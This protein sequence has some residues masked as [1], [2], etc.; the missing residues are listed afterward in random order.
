MR[1]KRFYALFVTR[2]REFFR[3]RAALYWNFMF[4][5]IIILGF[6]LIFQRDPGTNYKFGVIPPEAGMQKFPGEEYPLEKTG[7]DHPAFH[8]RYREKIL[9]AL[10]EDVRKIESV[11]FLFF[12]NRQEGFQ[13]LINHRVDMLLSPENPASGRGNLPSAG[14]LR[15]YINESSPKGRMSESLLVQAVADPARIARSLEKKTVKGRTIH[16]IDW[17]FPGI[18][19]MNMMFSGLFG[20]GYVIVRYRKIG[21]L[22]RLKA[23]PLQPLEYLCAQVASRLFVIL[24]IGVVLYAGCAFVFGF[25]CQGSYLDLVLFFVFGSTSIVS[26]GL[27]VAARTASEEFASGMLNLMTWPMMFLSEVWFSLEGANPWVQKFA[28]IFPLKHLTYGMRRIMNEGA[29]LY[30][31]LPEILIFLGMTAVFLAIGSLRF[32][33]VQE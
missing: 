28:M 12:E 5:F 6:A 4:P 23:T 24:F 16:Y 31:L 9:R 10:P 21:T 29:A 7:D 19:A 27:L 26:L 32:K 14:K 3:D 11:Q 25:T 22:K 1:Y 13:K 2:N 20:V 15:Y 17:L 33:W 30:E 8:E 18:I